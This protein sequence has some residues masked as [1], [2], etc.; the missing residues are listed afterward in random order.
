MP[1]SHELRRQLG[2]ALAWGD[3]HVTFERAVEGI[4]AELRGRRAPGLPHSAW[5]LLE[6]LRITQ[7]D[8]LAFCR[9]APYAHLEWPKDYWPSEEAPTKDDAWMTSIASFLADRQELVDLALSEGV[10]LFAVVPNGTDQTYLREL[11]LVIDHG[12][13]HIGQ[14]VLVRRALGIWEG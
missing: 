3:A 13:Y 14:L 11:L 10:D 5:E 8:I 4:P 7:A 1:K 6:H 12:A 2:R 9:P